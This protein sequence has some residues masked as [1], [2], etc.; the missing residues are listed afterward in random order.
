MREFV[1]GTLCHAVEIPI[2]S[3][4]ACASFVVLVDVSL[5]RVSTAVCCLSFAI[6]RL[7]FAIVVIDVVDK[8]ISQIY[9]RGI[10]ARRCVD[11]VAAKPETELLCV[12][13][14]VA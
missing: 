9:C 10:I 14:C 5:Q 13:A 6:Q 11:H 4:A 1:R 8:L 12:E 3:L 2:R 7:D